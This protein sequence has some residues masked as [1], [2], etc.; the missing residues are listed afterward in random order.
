[1]PHTVSH[2]LWNC[3]A[4][5]LIYEFHDRFSNNVVRDISFSLLDNGF[6]IVCNTN[7]KSDWW[8][9]T[10]VRDIPAPL[11]PLIV[12]PSFSLLFLSAQLSLMTG[13][14]YFLLPFVLSGLLSCSGLLLFF[15]VADYLFLSP[16]SL[17]LFFF[18]V[19]YPIYFFLVLFFHFFTP[20]YW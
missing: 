20:F 2:A 3:T 7:Y 17:L 15:L 10:N 12:F 5:F 11:L 19:E 13:A 1:M 18:V 4:S 8:Q 6:L 14:P 9:S 16:V